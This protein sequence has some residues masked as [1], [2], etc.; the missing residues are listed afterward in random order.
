MSCL[1]AR[2]QWR[3]KCKMSHDHLHTPFILFLWMI[4]G[5]QWPLVFKNSSWKIKPQTVCFLFLGSP[6]PPLP[7]GIPWKFP[8]RPGAFSKQHVDW[9]IK[10]Y[11]RHLYLNPQCWYLIR[12]LL[13]GWLLL[14]V[15]TSM[16]WRF[17]SKWLES[18]TQSSSCWIL[19]TDQLEN[20]IWILKIIDAMSW[21]VTMLSLL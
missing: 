10:G 8:S 21:S 17:I 11:P 14:F 18:V 1:F 12:N 7:S 13:N 20:G 3:M 6:R 2:V 4:L 15:W 19:Y 9:G 16:S 5:F